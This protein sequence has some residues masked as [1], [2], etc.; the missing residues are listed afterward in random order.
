MRYALA[1]VANE[2]WHRSYLPSALGNRVRADDPKLEYLL[3]IAD[4]LGHLREE[5]DFANDSVATLSSTDPV[6]DPFDTFAE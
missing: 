3:L 2:R 6:D 1:A 4:A 5:I